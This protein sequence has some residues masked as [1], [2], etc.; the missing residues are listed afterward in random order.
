[1]PEYTY[2]CEECGHEF[3]VHQSFSEEAL[4]KCP[5][6]SKLA[7]RK[8][9]KPARVVFKGSGFYVTDHRSSSRVSGSGSEKEDDKT[10]SSAN[11]K[12]EVASEG[13]KKGESKAKKPEAAKSK[14]EN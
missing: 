10:K 7:L 13:E 11:G 3:D 12:S 1:M 4:K 8:V 9:Y 5:T 2:H 6:C 14:S